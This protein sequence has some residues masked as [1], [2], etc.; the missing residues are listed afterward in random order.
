MENTNLVTRVN[1]RICTVEK[2]ITIVAFSVMLALLI[3]QVICRYCFNW[4][5]AWAEEMVRYTYIAVSFVG[6]TVALRESTHISIDILPNLLN[7]TIKN[8]HKRALVQDRID[9]FA[10]AVG[11]VFWAVISFWMF[12]YNVDIAE[13]GHITTCNEWPMWLMCLPVT[14]SC[15]MMGVHSILNAIEKIIDIKKIKKIRKESEAK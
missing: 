11:V 4:P 9:V 8:E 5:L 14:I 12:Q 1:N 2:A 3:I 13:R 7:I 6:A 15:I 10:L